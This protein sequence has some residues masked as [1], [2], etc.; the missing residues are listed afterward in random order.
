MKLVTTNIHILLSISHLILDYMITDNFRLFIGLAICVTV[1]L[2]H[3]SL[4]CTVDY[5]VYNYSMYC[6]IFV[7]NK[8]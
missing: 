3:T 7:F 1:Y 8:K 4:L 2:V 5:Y 6:H